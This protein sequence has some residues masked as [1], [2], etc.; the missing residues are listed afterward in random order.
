VKVVNVHEAKT[1]LSELLAEIERTGSSYVICRSGKPVAKLV[2]HEPRDRLSPHP[3]M[4]RIRI[5]YDPTE[6]LG[7]E[8]WPEADD[9]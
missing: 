8:D 2:G 6:P 3:A 7:V 4:R 9:A 5:S 1:R